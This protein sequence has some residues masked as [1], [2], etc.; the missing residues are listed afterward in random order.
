MELDRTAFSVIPLEEEG[1][2]RRM[3][4]VPHAGQSVSL[5][6]FGGYPGIRH[7][8]AD[9]V[10]WQKLGF[11]VVSFPNHHSNDGL[12]CVKDRRPAVGFPESEIR[13]D[14][15]AS[16]RMTGYPNSYN[17]PRKRAETRNERILNAH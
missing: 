12:R 14:P 15:Y 17:P 10:G 11:V 16:L 7:Q 1:D 3:A 8:V 13:K 6:R 9:V 4:S 2:D 5:L